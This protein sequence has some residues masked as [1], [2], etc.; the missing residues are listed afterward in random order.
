MFRPLKGI[1]LFAFGIFAVADSL[2]G[3]VQKSSGPVRWV[4]LVLG[5]YLVVRGLFIMKPFAKER[6]AAAKRVDKPQEEA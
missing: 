2:L 3:I 6:I 4:Y 1:I 5:L